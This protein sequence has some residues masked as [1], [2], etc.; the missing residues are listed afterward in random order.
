MYIHIHCTQTYVITLTSQ[1][2]LTNQWNVA[3][4]RWKYPLSIERKDPIFCEVCDLLPF[5]SSLV[6]E[7]ACRNTGLL[8]ED[9]GVVLRL[10]RL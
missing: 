1:L 6:P 5:L 9:S 10:F 4:T 7:T 8:S 3:S 2:L